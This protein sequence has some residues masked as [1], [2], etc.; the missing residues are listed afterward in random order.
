MEAF[1]QETVLQGLDQQVS[2]AKPIMASREEIER[3][4]T[5]EYV[6][7]V[8][9]RSK[10]GEGY[11]DYGDTTTFKGI[12]EAVATVVGT[13]LAAAEERSPYPHGLHTHAT[14]SLCNIADE[15]SQS[16]YYRL[17]WWL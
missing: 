10:S 4:H 3:F 16:P 2:I 17:G 14:A 15:F 13:V 11:L 12:Y 8:I 5:A 9:T 7:R 1:W 6:D